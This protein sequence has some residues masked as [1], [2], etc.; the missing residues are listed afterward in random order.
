MQVPHRVDDQDRE[1]DV[2]EEVEGRGRH[3][4]AAPVPMP[5]QIL[6][7]VDQLSAH[8][9]RVRGADGNDLLRRDGEEE[10]DRPQVAERVGEYR[11]RRRERTHEQSAQTR[12][13]DLG[14]GASDLELR[15]SFHELGPVDQRREERLVRHVEEDGQRACD[16]AGDV[17][18]RE[19][20][21]SERRRHG[22]RAERER[23]AEVGGHH[24]RPARQAVDPHPG[25][26]GEE[27]ERQE[28]DRSERRYLERGRVQ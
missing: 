9:R 2:V 4:D 1:G 16:E 23:A 10:S 22:D 3:R 5:E 7:P 27:E 13:T 14:R 24:D 11:I 15:V 12:P 26:K 8:R 25:R 19:R 28:V 6:D 17:Q 20:Q 21:V 18:L